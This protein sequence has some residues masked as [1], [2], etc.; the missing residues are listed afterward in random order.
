MKRD[1]DITRWIEGSINLKKSNHMM[2]DEKII[3]NRKENYDIRQRNR[4]MENQLYN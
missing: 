2:T 3:D 4:F 1:S